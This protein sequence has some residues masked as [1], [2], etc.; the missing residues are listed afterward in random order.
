M[1]IFHSYVKLPEGRWQTPNCS[2]K[3]PMA[4]FS[5]KYDH[6]G[7]SLRSPILRHLCLAGKNF[8]KSNENTFKPQMFH[9]SSLKHLKHKDI[10]RCPYL[11]SKPKHQQAPKKHVNFS[12]KVCSRHATSVAVPSDDE[13]SGEHLRATWPQHV[14]NMSCSWL[15]S[16]LTYFFWYI[17]YKWVS[18]HGRCCQFLYRG[19]VRLPI[20]CLARVMFLFGWIA[21]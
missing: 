15:K 8:I 18:K 4:R 20:S 10:I 16:K 6:L 12:A 21:H 14:L 5:L 11:L 17:F 2:A 3:N 7:C 19:H 13:K 1:V 9:I